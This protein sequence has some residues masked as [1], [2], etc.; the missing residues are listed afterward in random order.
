MLTKLLAIIKKGILPSEWAQYNAICEQ[1]GF[2]DTSLF[3]SFDCDTD[4]DAAAS[5]KI[6]G[7]LSGLDL[8]CSFAVPGT[9]LLNNRK[10]YAHLAS[11]GFEFLNHGMLP[12][13]AW[14]GS[15]Y[16]GITFYD[17]MSLKEVE[18]DIREGDRVVREVTGQSPKGFRASHFG[19]FQKPEEVAFMHRICADLGYT[20]ASTTLPRYALERGPAFLSK[21]LVELPVIGSWSEPHTILDSWNYLEDR[22]NYRLS[23]TYFNLFEETLR[24]VRKKKL[25]L[26][27]CWYADPCHVFEQKP[28]E[29][30]MKLITEY[31]IPSYTGSQCAA[32]F[33]TALEKTP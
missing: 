4:L 32:L 2:S 26:L 24:M 7:F 17:E 33:R 22:V 29:N 10:S 11:L 13:A 8:K 16:Y 1:L 21:G 20:Y 5:L 3:L 15:Q 9:Q 18:E 30:A 14:N 27:L 23:E 19:S 31:G 25:P 12:H 6:A 28:F